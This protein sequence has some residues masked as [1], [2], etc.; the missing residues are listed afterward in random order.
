MALLLF[1]LCDF[2]DAIKTILSRLVCNMAPACAM[3]RD[4]KKSRSPPQVYRKII[5][6]VRPSSVC[7][8]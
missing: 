8:D 4:L 5:M 2:M 3:A 6:T 7:I 1:E